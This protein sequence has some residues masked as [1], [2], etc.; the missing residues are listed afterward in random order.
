MLHIENRQ[1]LRDDGEL[2]PLVERVTACLTG[3]APIQ[4]V[5]R[6][7][8]F[9]G[10]TPGWVVFQDSQQSGFGI[11]AEGLVGSR[12]NLR[13]KLNG[14]QYTRRII[15][16]FGGREGFPLMLTDRLQ[17]PAGW[18]LYQVAVRT[19]SVLCAVSL[20][21]PQLKGRSPAVPRQSITVSVPFI[22]TLPWDG[23]MNVGATRVVRTLIVEC[24]E[25]RFRGELGVSEEGGM[26]IQRGSAV[27][28][29]EGGEVGKTTEP[30]A[31]I[32]LDIGEIELSLQEIVALRSGSKIELKAELPLPC[33]MRVGA[34]TLAHGELQVNDDSIVLRIKEVMG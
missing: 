30:G 24:R 9:L 23:L 2:L 22:A 14:L 10:A 16:E 21:A 12:T 17:C 33:F 20:P 15:E 8:R 3:G 6:C 18:V 32:R 27:D 11:N 25:Q 7:P 5:Q 28:V 13:L 1:Q 4:S 19:G 29:E 26:S 31:L 34:T